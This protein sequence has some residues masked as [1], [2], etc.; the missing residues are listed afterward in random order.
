VD[1][2]YPLLDH[3]SYSGGKKGFTFEKFV[4]CHMECFLE[5]A[6]FHEPILETKMV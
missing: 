5:L 3:L 1:D 6:H 2:A 4:Q